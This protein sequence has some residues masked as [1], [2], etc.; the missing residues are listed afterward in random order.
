MKTASVGNPV[1]S[2]DPGKCPVV[3]KKRGTE[4]DPTSVSKSSS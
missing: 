1:S 4:A 2:A 3:G